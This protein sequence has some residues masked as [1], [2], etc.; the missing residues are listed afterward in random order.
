MTQSKTKTTTKAKAKAKTATKAKSKSTSKTESTPAVK[1]ATTATTGRTAP[2]AGAAPSETASPAWIDQLFPPAAPAPAPAANP[3]A[4]V[5]PP[6]AT[7]AGQPDPTPKPGLP[8]EHSQFEDEDTEMVWWRVATAMRGARRE[9]DAAARNVQGAHEAA[10]ENGSAECVLERIKLSLEFRQ[11]ALRYLDDALRTWHACHPQDPFPDGDPDTLRAELGGP[12]APRPVYEA[13]FK[14]T[15]SRG[16]PHW[17]SLG[18]FSTVAAARA[19][20]EKTFGDRPKSMAWDKVD[21]HIK[22]L[23]AE[24]L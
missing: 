11:A 8:H 2:P 22:N 1:T 6:R 14:L 5:A 3:P 18:L 15:S 4:G 13:R 19:A 21:V 10:A 9:A 16:A 7:N 20:L 17:Q 12:V 23:T 24:S